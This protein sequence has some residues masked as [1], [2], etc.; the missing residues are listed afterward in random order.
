MQPAVLIRLH[1]A[2]PWRYGPGEGG[3]DGM[4]ALYRSDRVYSA[5]TI[6]MAQLGF[7]E[8]WLQATARASAPAL[9]FSSMFPFQADVL[10]APPPATLWPPS[11]SQVTAP[12]PVF[13][14]KVRWNAARFVPLSLIEW[15]LTGESIVADQWIPDAESGCLLRRDRPNSSPF[16]VL[17]RTTAAVDRLAHSTASVTSFACVEFEP[18]S[19]FWTAVRYASPAAESTWHNKIESAFRLLA[20]TGF[21]GRRSIGWGRTQALEYQHG[22]WPG[23][24]M[25]KLDKLSPNGNQSRKTE[26]A[27]S[28]YWLLSLYSPCPADAIDWRE[29][30]Y[31]LTVR[32][33]RVE[34]AAVV[35]AEKKA[36]RMVSEGS[37]LAAK[38]EPTGAAIDVAP[39]GFPHPVYR[40]GF[41]L[42]LR[43]P[44]LEFAAVAAR[45]ETP[46]T[47]EAL[48]RLPCR[49][50]QS[51]PL[52]K[53]A[54]VIEGS[55]DSSDAL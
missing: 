41:A 46:G 4:D 47:E 8:E 55:E 26:G 37:V 39:D 5:V 25:P 16:R 20:D 36:A 3:R 17:T 15:V 54:D 44:T 2:G 13:L 21:G 53:N 27:T 6:A 33:G 38:G 19:G 10:F 31:Q 24:M 42:A 45:V 11:P 12:S 50:P 9:V 52:M 48:E 49:E 7:L 43:L 29:G 1:P 30:D 34:S 32:G 22:L 28:L 18:G 14:S 23:L 35:S 40:S 51:D